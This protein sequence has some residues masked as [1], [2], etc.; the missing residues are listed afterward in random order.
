MY[1]T[2]ST[3]SMVLICLK[4]TRCGHNVSGDDNVFISFNI[5]SNLNVFDNFNDLD[6]IFSGIFE[7]SNMFDG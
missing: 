2:I 6:M 5:S 3:Y 1:L 7:D 4:I